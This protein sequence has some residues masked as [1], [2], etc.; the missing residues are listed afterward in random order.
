MWSKLV[1]E[2]ERERGAIFY[3]GAF[4]D[5]RADFNFTCRFSTC[6]N[7]ED[8]Y[9]SSATYYDRQKMK[10][11][12]R[13]YDCGKI[14]FQTEGMHLKSETTWCEEDMLLQN[15]LRDAAETWL[16][17]NYPDFKNPFMYWE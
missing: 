4:Y 1:D 8:D 17:Q 10:W 16:K 6:C 7:P 13:V 11:Y 5:R 12:G 3:K 2:K 9:K 14:I 15:A